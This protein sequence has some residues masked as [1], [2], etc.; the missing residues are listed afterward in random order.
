MRACLVLL[1]LV[2]CSD[3]LAVTLVRD[4]EAAV[5]VT[6]A[7]DAS[8]VEEQAAREL[9]HYLDLAT[10]AS[11]EL[12]REGE[13]ETGAPAIRVG[14]H[15]QA[16]LLGPE[17]WV[18]MSS[19]EQ[20]SLYGGGPRGTLYAV[21][22]FLEEHVGVR[23]WTPRDEF[24]PRL[25]QL[26]VP[27][28]LS[29]GEPSFRYRDI[30]GFGAEPRFA[31][32]SRLNGHFSRLPEE[33]GGSY[34]FGPPRHVHNFY[35]YVQPDRHFET[36]PDFFSELEG[37]RHAGHAQLCL[38][39]PDLPAVVL[40][41]LRDFI[42]GSRGEQEPTMFSFSPNDWGGACDCLEC[43]TL[44]ERSGGQGGLLAAFINQLAD[45]IREEYPDILIDTLAYG[46]TMPPPGEIK[47]RDNVVV[48]YSA[49][50]SRKMSRALNDP[51]NRVA[52]KALD[53]WLDATSHLIIWDYAVSYGADG[54]LPLANLPLLAEDFRLYL[55][56]G[57]EGIFLQHD[58]PIGAD[59]RALKLWVL[60]KLMEDPH[61][62][63]DR[64]VE[65]FT[66]GYYGSAGKRIRRY[67]ALLGRAMA[68]RSPKIGYGSTAV[69][70]THLDQRFLR[71]AQAIFD[72]AEESIKGDALLLRRLRHARLSLDRATLLLRP[73]S[74]SVAE[75]YRN[76]WRTEIMRAYPASERAAL[77][78]DVERELS[79][80]LSHRYNRQ[81][82]A[83][84]DRP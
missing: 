34:R 12:R 10:G 65:Q 83:I 66:D 53:G 3:L 45:A 60:A 20:L 81:S 1:A 15:G 70:Y 21:Y 61:R 54:D 77:L 46:Y 75:R 24:V 47:L 25:R 79:V 72:R 39:N 41:N 22:R 69:E 59:M 16:A 44:A 23:W 49:F 67:L 37:I 27:Q 6:L 31:A 48:R 57:A 26:D 68:R 43:R 78:E 28:L 82:I 29:R 76:T 74:R 50:Q 11:F 40:A 80:L 42:D 7:A 4:G 13:V 18:I 33:L 2:A 56:S 8:P 9:I 14:L 64:L 62:D 38:S 58:Y 73:E 63:L 84:E 35:D 17:E 5:S 52:R 36:R 71:R 55:A 30:Y 19:G 51:V 32:H